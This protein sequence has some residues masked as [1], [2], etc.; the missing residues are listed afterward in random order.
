MPRASGVPPARLARNFRGTTGD[1]R[2]TCLD[3]KA[4]AARVR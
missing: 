1:A 2:E 3:A 4:F